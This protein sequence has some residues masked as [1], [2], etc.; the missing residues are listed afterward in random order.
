MVLY[1]TD[2]VELEKPKTVKT[3]R[4]S[5]KKTE[6]EEL[7]MEQLQIEAPKPK[8]VTKKKAVPEIKK[9]EEPV[10]IQE[11]PAKKTRKRKL[12]KVETKV[13]TPI[14]ESVPEPE[15]IAPVSE[16][17]TMVDE[18]LK[19]TRK[20]AEKKLRAIKPKIENE[21]PVW[22]QKYVAGVQKEKAQ[23]VGS[24]TKKQEKEIKTEA[25]KTAHKSWQSGV[26]RD[27]VQGEVDSHSNLFLK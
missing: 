8:R 10:L 12:A 7:P 21:P 19:K 13:E 23:S 6:P 22:F 24:V 27:R 25:I 18:P 1:A 3:K 9:E 15:V 5:K 26:T 16:S 14:K 20:V 17:S 4:V 11:P 2:L